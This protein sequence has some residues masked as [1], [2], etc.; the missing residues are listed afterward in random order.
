MFQ[1]RVGLF[2]AL[3]GMNKSSCCG[4][5]VSSHARTVGQSH[6]AL[7]VRSNPS[8]IAARSASSRVDANRFHLAA[9]QY[10]PPEN[11]S[12]QL[13]PHIHRPSACCPSS[14]FALAPRV[15]GK[16]STS[17][18][19]CNSGCRMSGPSQ[20]PANNSF[21]WMPLH[22]LLLRVVPGRHQLTQ[23]LGRAG[24]RL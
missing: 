12:P 19:W 23:V 20:M 7:S 21:N 14:I 17:G 10:P 24:E 2:P 22:F 3:A 13:N 8:A 6:D 4:H 1:G 9:Q 16:H 5:N 11:P 18:F 15:I